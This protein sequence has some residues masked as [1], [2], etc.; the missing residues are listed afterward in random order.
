M[1]R[2]RDRDKPLLFGV[3]VEPSDGA[4]PAGNGGPGTAAFFQGA[5]VQF[6]VGA[7]HR[8]RRTENSLRLWRSHQKTNW[9]RS[10]AYASLVRPW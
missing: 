9:R 5:G 3:A 7:A 10:S 1:H 8:E 2:W 6:D 4:Q